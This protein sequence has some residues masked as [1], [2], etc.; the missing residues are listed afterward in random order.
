MVV[1]KA[2]MKAVLKESLW[3]DQSVYQLAVSKAAKKVVESAA[4]LAALLA[5]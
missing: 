2:L 5:V 3:A 1:G 4:L